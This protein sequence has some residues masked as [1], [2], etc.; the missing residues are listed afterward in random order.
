MPSFIGVNN[1]VIVFVHMF[2]LIQKISSI[3][4]AKSNFAL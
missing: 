3:W 2:D 1:T 4:L